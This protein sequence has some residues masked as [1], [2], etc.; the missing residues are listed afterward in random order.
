MKYGGK[1]GLIS[2]SLE[3]EIYY[4]KPTLI[5]LLVFFCQ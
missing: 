1:Y 4:T 5:M 3:A 2:M